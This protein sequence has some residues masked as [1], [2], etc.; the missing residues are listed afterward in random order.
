MKFKKIIKGIIGVGVMGG[1]AYLAYKI[2]EGNDEINERYRDKYGDEDN[3]IEE[4]DDFKFYD[5]LDEPDDGCIAPFDKHEDYSDH[6]F[7]PLNELNIKGVSHSQIEG[8]LFYLLR[9]GT[10]YCTDVK[11]FLNVTGYKAERI[12]EALEQAGY[13]GRDD[14]QKKHHV[15]LSLY[16]LNNLLGKK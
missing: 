15:K 3:E 7:K 16:D 5:N 1:V 9:C 4:D 11:R 6:Y 8:L 2:G 14:S 13:I 10:F 12:C